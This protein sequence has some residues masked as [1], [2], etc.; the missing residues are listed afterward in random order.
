MLDREA[1]L[2]VENIKYTD[3]VIKLDRVPKNPE[4]HAK[5]LAKE[6]MMGDEKKIAASLRKRRWHTGS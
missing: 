1:G 2:R 6:V 4:V 3:F 5:R